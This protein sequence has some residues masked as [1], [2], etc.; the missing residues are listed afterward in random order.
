MRLPKLAVLLLRGLEGCG[1]S[2]YTRHLKAFFDDNGEVCDLFAL[3]TNI[4]RADTSSDMKVEFFDYAECL[5]LVSKL[6]ANYDFVLI[7]SVPAKSFSEEVKSTY[8]ERII[9]ELKMPKWMVNLDHHFL[10]FSRNADYKNAIE[11]CDGV[12]CYSLQKTK[13]GFINWLEKHQISVPVRPINNFF[14]IP[15]I[16]RFISAGKKGRSKRLINAGRAVAWKRGSIVLNLHSELARRG[17][18][19]EMI[20]F[21]RSIAGYTQ[22]RNYNNELVW[23]TT[24]EF[25]KPVNGPSAFSNAKLN[26]ALFDFLDREGQDPNLMYVMGSYDY[27]RGLERISK[28]AFATH[29]RSFEHNN[30]DYGNNFEFQGLEAALLSVPIFHRHFLDTVTLPGTTTSLSETEVFLSV[31]DD[32]RHL[33]EGGPQVLNRENFVS[34]LDEIWNDDS[35]YEK[36]RV[37]SIDL[38]RTY[39]SSDVVVPEFILSL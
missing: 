10:S 11:A 19:T 26:N 24:S 37:N 12:F 29:P 3:S 38:V 20:G 7:F 14:H 5:Q 4:G 2:N 9:S 8:V 17:F 1:V 39:Y 13:A 15:L 28:S 35:T 34:R 21:E 32:N 22:L 27:I 25:E 30:L 18:V 23:F 36:Y 33:K 16:E 6:N 31:D